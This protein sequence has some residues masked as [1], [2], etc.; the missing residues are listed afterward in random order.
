M[1]VNTGWTWPTWP[2]RDSGGD[3][4]W[5]SWT[6]SK[7]Y[8]LPSY[9]VVLWDCLFAICISL[10]FSYWIKLLYKSAGWHGIPGSTRSSWSPWSGRAR[11]SCK[12]RKSLGYPKVLN[13]SVSVMSLFV[14][15]AH[16]ICWESRHTL[17]TLT[18]A[19]FEWHIV[20]FGFVYRDLKDHRV[21]KGKKDPMAKGFLDQRYYFES[22]IRE[23]I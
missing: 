4:Y 11:P 18:W 2:L 9:F 6:K 20:H 8:E 16:V 12:L 17:H 5:T 23:V 13:V 7:C 10:W 14:S 22:I 1:F 15:V 3:W 21:F 19:L